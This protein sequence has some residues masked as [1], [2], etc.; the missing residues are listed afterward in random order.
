MCGLDVESIT[1]TH[2]LCQSYELNFETQ[3]RIPNMARRQAYGLSLERQVFAPHNG[4]AW[5]GY[6]SKVCFTC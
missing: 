5:V 3:W 6:I 4:T 1:P 2:A